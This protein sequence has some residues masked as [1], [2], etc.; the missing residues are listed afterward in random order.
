MTFKVGIQQ[1]IQVSIVGLWFFNFFLKTGQILQ[2][3]KI[4]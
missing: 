2:L 1:L 3:Y 4:M